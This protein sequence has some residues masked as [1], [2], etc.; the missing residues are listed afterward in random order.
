ML[1]SFLE[2]YL[3]LSELYFILKEIVPCNVNFTINDLINN[4]VVLEDRISNY[5]YKNFVNTK[6]NIIKI[7]DY[8]KVN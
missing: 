5:Q 2:D 3:E 1:M 8:L 7:R 6:I 4:E